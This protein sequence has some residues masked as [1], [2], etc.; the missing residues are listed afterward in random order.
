MA[1]MIGLDVLAFV[2]T[3]L[4]ACARSG[5]R[6]AM[7]AVGERLIRMGEASLFSVMDLTHH[8]AS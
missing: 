3:N 7:R 2:A 5:D 4:Q 8:G 1:G 6:T